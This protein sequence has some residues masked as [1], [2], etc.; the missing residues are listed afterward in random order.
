MVSAIGEGAY[1]PVARVDFHRTKYGPEILVDVAWVRE[2]PTFLRFDPHRL[3][4]YDILLVTSGRGW[5]WLDDCR[6]RVGPG[7]LF[8]T[9]PG[10]IRRWQVEGLDGLC[11]FFP[12]IFLEEFFQDALLVH[13]L[14]YFHGPAAKA[15]LQLATRDATSLRRR[16]LAMRRELHPVRPD[17]T[18][19]LRAGLYEVLFTLARLNAAVRRPAVD[20]I[21]NR[22]VVRF[23]DLV[24][25]E[26]PRCHMVADYAR[27]LA[28]SP[29]HLN[30]L[31]HRFLGRSA[32][33]LVQDRLVLEARRLLLY[34]DEPA[35]RVGHLLGFKDPS[36]FTR[37]FR[38]ATGL[39]PTEFLRRRGASAR[40]I[41]KS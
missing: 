9:S 6:W 29:G 2:M 10:Q 13:R 39:P 33:G 26:F 17:S 35:G 25:S 18:H 20:R 31:C 41:E 4:F 30:V 19:L 5:F 32:K 15:S 27:R 38:R 21:P 37:F 7:R 23:R 14:P 16:L 8:F 3:T 34:S 11:L 28:V 22:V 36:Y 12:S 1:G 24:E 40:P